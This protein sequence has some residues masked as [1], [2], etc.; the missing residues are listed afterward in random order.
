MDAN[1][2]WMALRESIWQRCYHYCCCCCCCCCEGLT[3]V[4]SRPFYCQNILSIY[5][6]FLCQPSCKDPTLLTIVDHM[7]RPCWDKFKKTSSLNFKT[8]KFIFLFIVAFIQYSSYI[9]IL[10]QHSILNIEQPELLYS[11]LQVGCFFTWCYSG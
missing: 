6:P 1:S 10:L 2:R 8:M 5:K 9:D 3:V 11:K 4:G 7:V